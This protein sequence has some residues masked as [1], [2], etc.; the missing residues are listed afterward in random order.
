M[1]NNN[2]KKRKRKF[3]IGQVYLTDTFAGPR[4]KI[5]L[6][7]KE[8]DSF[9]K[10]DIWYGTLIDEEDAK[11]LHKASVPY[12]KINIDESIV[13]EWLIVKNIRQPGKTTKNANTNRKR[14][15]RRKPGSK[16]I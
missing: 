8:I 5:K 14:G 9:T 2:T 16:P 4:V 6:T 11:A 1:T 7:R 15:T 3:K 10:Q 12:S 13:F